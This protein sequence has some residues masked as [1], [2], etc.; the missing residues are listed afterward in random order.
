MRYWVYENWA[1]ESK[2]VIHS[3]DCRFCN[4]GAGTGRN[5]R[6]DRNGRWHGPFASTLDAEGAAHATGRPARPCPCVKT[7]AAFPS[8]AAKGAASAPEAT[9]L[10]RPGQTFAAK[11]RGKSASVAIDLTAPSCDLRAAA[12]EL[13]Q[14]GFVRAGAWHLDSN[15]RGGVRFSLHAHRDDRVVYCFAV[16][17][18]VEYIGICDSTA[19][20]L[21]ER[22]SRYQ[23]LTGAGTNARIAE[24]IRASLAAGATVSIYAMRPAVGPDH[25]NLSVDYVKGLEY[26]LIER[27]K[28]SWNR[29]R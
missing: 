21:R 13:E 2:A 20:T 23:A 10:L 25:V 29:R 16:N 14:F 26:P 8:G 27:L 24:Q 22:M 12:S 17:D 6:G 5:T 9:A 18:R 28:P 4:D 11:P 7:A 19:T 15:M 1:A 3:G